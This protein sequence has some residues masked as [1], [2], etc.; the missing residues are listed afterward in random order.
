MSGL[1]LMISFLGMA[2]RPGPLKQESKERIEAQRVAF[3]TQKLSLSPDEAAKFW[4]VYNE[5]KTAIKNLR[6]DIE[7]PDLMSVSDDEATTII[8]RHFQMEQ[9]KLELKRTLFTR[10]RTVISPRKILMLHAAEREF[11]RE[12]LRRAN[13]FRK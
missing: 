3:I 12:L 2:Q 9:K 7:R 1:C 11:N 6:D 5:N 13:E 8:E 4:P 10:L